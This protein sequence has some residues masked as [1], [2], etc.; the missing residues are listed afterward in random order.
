MDTVGGRV[1][2]GMTA[3]A[4]VPTRYTAR[5]LHGHS[6]RHDTI[7]HKKTAPKRGFLNRGET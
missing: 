5:K 6:W 7:A 3:W 1:C 2:M 4:L